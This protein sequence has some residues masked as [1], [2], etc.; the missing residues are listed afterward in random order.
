MI[1]FVQFGSMQFGE[2]ARYFGNSGCKL[3]LLLTS[4]KFNVLDEINDIRQR[5]E[6]RSRALRTA[7]FE[8]LIDRVRELLRILSATLC[9][10]V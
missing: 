8:F 4:A 3:L 5:I 1:I 9:V 7:I 6:N 10:T 2:L